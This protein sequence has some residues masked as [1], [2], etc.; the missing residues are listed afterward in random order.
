M[1]KRLIA[2]ALCLLLV[3]LVFVS[4]GESDYDAA[5]EYIE[6]NQLTP[7]KP[8][9]TLNMYIPTNLATHEAIDP[10]VVAAMQA[11][12]NAIIEPKYRTRIQF[13][14]IDETEYESVVAQQYAVSATQ[15]DS[16]VKEEKTY[17][18][19]DKFPQLSASQCD[20]FVMTGKEMFDSYVAQNALCDLTSSLTTSY[21]RILNDETGRDKAI[22]SLIYD[23][24]NVDG[25]YYG[26][27]A[28]F[29][30]GF[31]S[32]YAIEREFY[33]KYYA[34]SGEGVT[35]KQVL[36]VLRS[37]DSEGFSSHVLEYTGD[38]RARFTI[39]YDGVN[40]DDYIILVD[41]SEAKKPTV[42]YDELFN[43]MFCIS[44][45]CESSSRALEVIAELYTNKELHSILQYGVKNVTYTTTTDA[46]GN[47]V[48]V[49]PIAEGP[50]YSISPAYTGNIL[51]L[52]PSTDPS[53]GIDPE[54][55]YYIWLQNSE[56]AYK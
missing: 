15:A 48:S 1:K 8:Y 17:L 39:P 55:A 51:T 46:S 21:S 35:T 9:L 40:T 12:F 13:C 37:A 6:K 16:G 29:K 3:T 2:L 18:L 45:T 36:N 52:Y 47:V 25:V 26:V 32:Y 50:A 34:P 22:C 42:T 30:I 14:L 41:D 20:I 33:N 11:E 4:C 10:A 24:A 19:N 53:L 56:A 54:N 38:Y 23:H 27:P 31:Y 43:G 28:N 49:T 5:K 44:R 7:E